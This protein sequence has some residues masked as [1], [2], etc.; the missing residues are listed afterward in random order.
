MPK[1]FSTEFEN[2]PPGMQ[3]F[4]KRLVA[5]VVPQEITLFGSRARGD[6]RSN[7]DFDIAIRFD[8]SREEAFTRFLVDSDSEPITLFKIDLVNF[9][10]LDKNYQENIEREGKVI[11]G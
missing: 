8:P 5:D 6:H 1:R 2:L 10:R 7:S 4:L 3:D 9:K 11:Y